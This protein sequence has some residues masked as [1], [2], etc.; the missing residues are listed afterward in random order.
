M[1]RSINGISPDLRARPLLFG[2]TTTDRNVSL[3]SNRDTADLALTSLRCLIG[4]RRHLRT[5]CER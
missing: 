3:S 2:C 4:D 1:L 5:P